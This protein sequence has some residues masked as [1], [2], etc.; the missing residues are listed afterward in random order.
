MAY[1]IDSN[2]LSE[3]TKTRPDPRVG[4][5]L[6]TYETELLIDSIILGELRYGILSMPS[7]KKRQVLE[8]WF[9]SIVSG[10]VCLPWTSSSALRWAELNVDM[11][12]KGLAM[13]YAD[14]M[15]AA[16]ALVHDLTIVTRNVKDFEHAGVDVINPFE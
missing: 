13:P 16:T 15:V 11:Q 8:Q 2:V 7:G 12:R 10:I 6:E 9:D 3:S 4:E 5:W 14:S 1:L